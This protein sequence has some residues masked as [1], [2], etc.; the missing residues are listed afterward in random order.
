MVTLG[1]VVIYLILVM[2]LPTT[3]S[4]QDSCSGR[5]A[6]SIIL[7]PSRTIDSAFQNTSGRWMFVSYEIEQKEFSQIHLKCTSGNEWKE[8]D[9]N[10]SP[11]VSV[12]GGCIPPNSWVLIECLSLNTPPRIIKQIEN[13]Y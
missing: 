2:L 8:L 12:L 1:I 4:A 5:I 6:D 13:I 11:G 3:S 9:S 10:S 7:N